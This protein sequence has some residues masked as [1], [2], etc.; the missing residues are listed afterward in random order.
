M[1]ALTVPRVAALGFT[2]GAAVAFGW[3]GALALRTV[4]VVT[5]GRRWYQLKHL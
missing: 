1:E 3:M 4:W 2:A 5:K